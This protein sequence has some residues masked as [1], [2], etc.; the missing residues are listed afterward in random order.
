MQD[1]SRKKEKNLTMNGQTFFY[2]CKDSKSCDAKLQLK[3]NN[4]SQSGSI[5]I[6]D[7]EHEHIHGEEQIIKNTIYKTLLSSKI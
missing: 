6:T 5:L 3:I 4:I 2:Q 1:G 7:S